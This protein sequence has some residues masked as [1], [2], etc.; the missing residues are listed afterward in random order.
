MSIDCILML[1]HIGYFILLHE[2]RV[3]LL[4]QQYHC[5]HYRATQVLPRADT[6]CSDWS[7]LA[8]LKRAR[9][10]GAAADHASCQ[11][12]AVP[13]EDILWSTKRRK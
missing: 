8:Q 5:E 13:Q 2:H 7:N 1:E 3:D 11:H 12:S 4:V 10:F 9:S 6:S